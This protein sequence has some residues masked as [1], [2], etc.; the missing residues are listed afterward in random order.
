MLTKETETFMQG[1]GDEYVPGYS[2]V[3]HR[4]V[5]RIVLG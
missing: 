4:M 2:A 3:G 1:Y 5:D